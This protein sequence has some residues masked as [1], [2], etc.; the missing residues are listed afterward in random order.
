[1]FLDEGNLEEE[2]LFKGLQMM[3]YP[4]I[5]KTSGNKVMV[6]NI[7]TF[8]YTH[9]HKGR[10]KMIEKVSARDRLKIMCHFINSSL[11]FIISSEIAII[12]KRVERHSRKACWW[13]DAA[14][15]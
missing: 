8:H 12:P 13:F 2:E 14:C 3:A 4:D 11:N 9:P 5:I 15:K 6:Y 7:I 1:M 10:W